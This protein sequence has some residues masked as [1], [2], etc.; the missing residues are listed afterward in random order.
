[1]TLV[2]ALHSDAA[3]IRDT[4]GLQILEGEPPESAGASGLREVAANLCA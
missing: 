4:S 2:V 3:R 1:M